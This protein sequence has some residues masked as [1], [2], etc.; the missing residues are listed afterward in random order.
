MTPVYLFRNVFQG[1]DSD[2]WNKLVNLWSATTRWFLFLPFILKY[3]NTGSFLD[4]ACRSLFPPLQPA[5]HLKQCMQYYLVGRQWSLRT[6]H[7]QFKSTKELAL[8]WRPSLKMIDCWI[9]LFPVSS[10]LLIL[11]PFCTIPGISTISV[12]LYIHS[13]RPPSLINDNMFTVQNQFERY[14]VA[15]SP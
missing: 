12:Y 11:C 2:P 3:T 9:I 13:A 15:G 6:L 8:T 5:S 4:L 7:V 10:S 1:M 14:S